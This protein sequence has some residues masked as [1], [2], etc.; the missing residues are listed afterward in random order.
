MAR[1]CNERL[2]ISSLCECFVTKKIFFPGMSHTPVTGEALGESAMTSSSGSMSSSQTFVPQV[3]QRTMDMAAYPP[4]IRQ[5]AGFRAPSINPMGISQGWYN[6][7]IFKYS[8]YTCTAVSSRCNVID[9]V[10][11]AASEV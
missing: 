8:C 9:R 7:K 5:A 6:F 10:R 2:V 4:E 3:S 11:N 1:S